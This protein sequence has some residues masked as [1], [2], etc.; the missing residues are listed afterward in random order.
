MIRYPRTH[1][2]VARARILPSYLGHHSYRL[3]HSCS[4]PHVSPSFLPT[5]SSSNC[6]S[7]PIRFPTLS[8]SFSASWDVKLS[9]FKVKTTL[10]QSTPLSTSISASP[11]THL[12]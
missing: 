3:H 2:P 6:R 8:H 4:S 1:R 7:L 10:Q 11:N 5:I 12:L 9:Q